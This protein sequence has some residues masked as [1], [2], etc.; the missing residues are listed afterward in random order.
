MA[1]LSAETVGAV[2][3]RNVKLLRRRR[4]WSQQELAMGLRQLG[5]EWSRANL[6]SLE[7]GRRRVIEFKTLLQLARALNASLPELFS[8][9]GHIAL[10]SDIATPEQVL[11]FAAGK[12]PWSEELE[13]G[14]TPLLIEMERRAIGPPEDIDREAAGRL[15]VSAQQVRA[16][17]QELFGR[18]L[19]EQLADELAQLPVDLAPA[20]RGSRRGH[21][22]QKLFR[23]L[24]GLKEKK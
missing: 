19:R 15:R 24:R 7:S 6:A 3:G 2:V 17:S 12:R 11:A 20:V 22:K 1:R 14:P 10:G 4:G 5:L 23:A 18:S 13:L 9:T 16:L 8:G 21:V